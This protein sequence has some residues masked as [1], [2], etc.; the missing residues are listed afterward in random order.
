MAATNG[1]QVTPDDLSKFSAE[2]SDLATQIPGY[3]SR[4]SAVMTV[5]T[6]GATNGF[7]AAM[8][9]VDKYND[10]LDNFVKPG[11]NLYD[12]QA[13]VNLVA[14]GADSA[15][16]G[17]QTTATQESTAANNVTPGTTGS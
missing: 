13:Q 10:V 9:L 3:G 1:F 4:Y 17:Y 12:L 11:S 14:E 8:D 7:Q 15:A 6:F 16:T 2:T 5:P